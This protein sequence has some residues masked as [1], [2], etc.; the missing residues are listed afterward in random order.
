MANVGALSQGT[1]L[2]PVPS[3]SMLAQY[4][5][6]PTSAALPTYTPGSSAGVPANS[7]TASSNTSVSAAVAYGNAAAAGGPL[8]QPWFIAV[9]LMVVAV[10]QIA[11]LARDELK[12]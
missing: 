9:I 6:G 10:V 2:T 8:A 1:T 5:N 7:S 11:H 12:S 3:Y 4:W